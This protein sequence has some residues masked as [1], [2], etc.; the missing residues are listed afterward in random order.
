MNFSVGAGNTYQF[1]YY[2]IYQGAS[3]TS[4]LGLGLTFPGMKT[5][6][7][8]V[9]INSGAEGTASKWSGAIT[10]SSGRIQAIS[11]QVANTNY[12][13]KI[14]GIFVVST[15]GSI[16]LQAN[17]EVSGAAFQILIMSGTTGR[18]CQVN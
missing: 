15:T 11:V 4:G 2:V 6:A 12:Y 18:I 7:C 16:A 10:A 8:D 9:N 3:T 1:T 14:E 17:A 13:A 5:F